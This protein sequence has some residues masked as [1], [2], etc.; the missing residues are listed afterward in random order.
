MKKNLRNRCF[1]AISLLTCSL[2]RILNMPTSQTLTKTLIKMLLRTVRS[3]LNFT[4]GWVIAI[5]LVLSACDKAEDVKTPTTTEQQSGKEIEQV[6]PAD[7]QDPAQ[8]SWTQHLQSY[9]QGWIQAEQD[10]IIRF[11]HEVAS[12]EQLNKPLEGIASISPEVAAKA[13]FTAEN[14][15]R[16][17]H[18]R[19]N[20]G[21]AYSLQLLPQKLNNIAPSLGPFKFQVQALRQ[22]YELNIAGLVPGNNK[23]HMTLTGTIKTVDIADPSN[24][25]KTL[26]L[27]Q[28]GNAR[29]ITWQHHE[30]QL[31][32]EFNIANI[33][34]EKSAQ[35]LELLY[36]ASAIGVKKQGSFPLQVPAIDQFA[37]TSVRTIQRPEQYVEVSFSEALD[38]KQNLSGLVQL[39]GKEAKTRIDGNYLR[40]YPGNKKSGVMPLSIEDTIKSTKRLQLTK[41]YQADVTFISELPGVRFVG[42]GS[43][44]PPNKNL[45]VPIEAINVNAVWVTAFKVFE[46]NIPTYLQSY[47]IAGNYAD[48]STGRYLWRKKISL[49]SV[50]FDKWQRYD[51]DMNE[52][53]GKH[54]QGIVNLEIS[55][56][57]ST[58]AFNCPNDNDTSTQDN[59]ALQ[60]Y[61][62]PGMDEASERPSWFYRYYSENNGY[63]T[64]YERRD[65]CHKEYFT[66]YG[67]ENIRASRNFVVSDLGLMAKKGK[68][69]TLHILATSITSGEPRANAEIKLYNY[70]HQLV[71]KSSTNDLGMATLEPSSTGFYL[72]AQYQNDHGYLR[73]PRNEALPT[74]QFDTGGE[75]VRQGLK[76][77][78]YGERDVWRPGDSI[79]LSFIL[80]DTLQRLPEG[81]PVSLDF[82]NPKGVK[83]TTQANS[84]PVGNLYTF[85]LK[86]DEDAP[87]GNWRAVVRVGGEYFDKVIKVETIVPNR[88]K[89]EVTPEQ[90]PI[91]SS[92]SPIQTELFAQ[93]LNGATAKNLKADSELKLRPMHTSFEGWSHYAF[94]DP[95][96]DFQQ[97][98]DQVFDGK[99]DAQGKAIFNLNLRRLQDAPG[100]LRATFVTRVFE[101]SGNFSTNIRHTEVLPYENWVG[102]QIPKGNGYRDAISRDQDHTIN[103]VALNGEGQVQAGRELSMSIYRIRWRWWWDQSD[104]NLANYIRRRS[105]NLI[106]EAALVT[107]EDG[108]AEFTLQKN[109]YDWG[110]HL[111][112]VCDK[113][114][115]HCAGQEVYLGWSWSN[116]VNPDTATQ[117]MLATDKEKYRVGDTA[118]IRIPQLK[119]GRVFYSLESGSKVLQQQWA[120]IAQGEN[121]FTIPI[122]EDMAPNVYVN[123][124]LILPHLARESDAPIRLYGITPLL[125]DNPQ[126]HITPAIESPEKVRPESSFEVTVHEANHRSMQY[127]LAVVDEGLLGITG[128]TAPDPHNSFYRREALGVST[129][130]MFDGVIGAYGANLERLLHIGGGA[131]GKDGELRKQR[132]FPPVVRFLGAFDLAAGESK[133]HTINLPQYMGAVRVMVVAA[134]DKAYG[135]AES[136]VRVTQPLTLLATLPRVLG[137]QEKVALPINVFVSDESIKQVNVEVIADRLFTLE[138]STLNFTFEE[139]GDQI[140]MLDM[141]VADTLGTGSITVIASAGDEKAEHTIHIESRSPNAASTRS[142]SRLLQPGEVWQPNLLPHGMENTNEASLTVSSF[143]P[144]NLQERLRYLIRYP[145]GCVEQTT[146]AIFPQIWLKNI[147]DLD[148]RQQDEIQEN[149][150]IAIRKYKSFQLANGAF[151]YWP[152]NAYYNDWASNY[153]THFLIEAK[154]LGYAVP[155]AVLDDAIQYLK[156]QA[157]DFDA[158][159]DY[160]RLVGAYRLYVLALA[161]KP[162][163]AS[164]NRLRESLLK[165]TSYYNDHVARWQLSLAY[166][167]LGLLDVAQELLDHQQNTVKDYR[168][169]DYTYGS[170]LRDQA[171]LLMTYSMNGRQSPAWDE[172]KNI[173]RSLSGDQWYSTQTT[174]WALMALSKYASQNTASQHRF[175]LKENST[176]PE[177]QEITSI[178][179]IYKQAIAPA[180]L[181]NQQLLV[182][183]DSDKPLYA[184]ISNSGVPANQEEQA[185]SEGLQLDI[186]FTT[187]E[188]DPIEPTSLPQG[189]DF[190]AVVK[191]NALQEQRQFK[192]EDI[193]LS[194]IMPSGWQIRNERLEGDALSKGLDYQDIRDDRVLS[195]FSLWQN[196]RWWYRYNDNTHKEQTVRVVL[197]ASFAGKFYLPGW[198]VSSMYDDEIKA[199]SKGRWV[200]VL[201]QGTPGNKD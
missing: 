118:T 12:E 88:L 200:E 160:S 15:L 189:Q 172:A 162:E 90:T 17:Q 50:P 78:I 122:T 7:P 131:D 76:G 74:S 157:N 41:A 59:Q 174:A 99:L 141:Q 69:N 137:P 1:P 188:G 123:A 36:S 108:R 201:T 171:I 51:I 111:I 155:N 191:V 192:I 89:V 67:T 61:E 158:G 130:D 31:T 138:T 85:T 152:G 3:T 102:M 187:M 194:M 116:Q 45:T 106:D 81:H 109:K 60:S 151:S 63:A 181:Q 62:G 82:F 13:I 57:K 166:Q 86:T 79:Y 153:A 120:N 180:T 177:W 107:R 21:Q 28:N 112:R 183:N 146:S 48:N 170:T 196:Y 161:G 65:P 80:Q 117:L 169:S 126:S 101:Q 49:P 159:H 129:W 147:V 83:V 71:G 35:E 30:D 114:S 58:I 26:S 19:L 163:L 195:Y 56:D 9:T 164:M 133:T 6:Q 145:H 72:I 148:Q 93:W 75:K 113:Q 84:Q 184:N 144:I 136:T 179:T 193:A 32:H 121:S 14:E 25:E 165:T 100:K 16:I 54:S 168:Y 103:F 134:G 20:S 91:H 197:N 98:E 132:R 190:I 125:V 127:T 142:A 149:V 18:E 115:G 135:K 94:D 198:H 97:F 33:K 23:G 176:T 178:A 5:S 175:A 185:F 182:R 77:F 46:E 143:P 4:L 55:I 37:V 124:V 43:I 64:Y 139:P 96:S 105:N 95:A 156:N 11:K 2:S 24:V 186:A 22:D 34:R 29:A 53:L 52:I 140:A 44:I 73:L 70:Q 27:T 40:I 42:N 66:Y 104:E 119:Q 167:K 92:Q 173:A 87:T 68:H 38:R 8:P 154:Q 199:Q 10:I 47:N 150:D 128:F 110:R 39:D